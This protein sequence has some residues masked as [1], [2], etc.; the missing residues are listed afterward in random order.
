ML[1]LFNVVVVNDAVC[2]A[3]HCLVVLIRF[4]QVSL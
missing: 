4:S 1:M 2:S 3:L